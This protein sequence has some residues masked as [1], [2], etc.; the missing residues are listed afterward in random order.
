M[1]KNTDNKYGLIAILMHW[2]SVIVIIGLFASGLWMVTLDY[3]SEWYYTTPNIHKAVGV[4]FGALVLLRLL[5]RF[6]DR[7]PAPEPGTKPWEHY[8]AMLVHGLLYLLMFTVI[9]LGYLLATAD[10]RS[11]DVF[12]WFQ[13][14]SSIRSIPDQA[15]LTGKLHLWMAWALIGTAVLHA[16]AAFKHHFINRDSTLL[17]MFGLRR[18]NQ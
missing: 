5:W 4:L 14:P 1:I 12:G 13:L 8:A 6:V 17:R 2:V 11:V 18:R 15:V 9:L 16:L 3:Y 7:P 10:G